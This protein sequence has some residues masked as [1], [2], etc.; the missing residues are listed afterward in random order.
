[1]VKKTSLRNKISDLLLNEVHHFFWTDPFNNQG[2]YDFGYNCRDHAFVTALLLKI[3]EYDPKLIYGKLTLVIDNLPIP[4]YRH[5]WL[6]IKDHGICDLSI[7]KYT[8][9]ILGVIEIPIK[10]IFDND[11]HPKEKGKLFLTRNEDEYLRTIDK[12]TKM[13]HH[14]YA[15]YFKQDNDLFTKNFINDPFKSIDT[16]ILGSLRKKNFDNSIYFKLVLH[17]HDLSRKKV[18]T[19]KKFRYD[20]SWEKINNNIKYD[21]AIERVITLAKIN[22]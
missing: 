9:T 17:L 4:V 22:D 16:P 7:K 15:I 18:H 19:L 5:A 2:E 1:M 11:W 13:G 6:E 12:V 20:E 14:A 3:W 21:N 10:G 8:Q